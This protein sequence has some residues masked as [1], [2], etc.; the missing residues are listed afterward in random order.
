M[1]SADRLFEL[2]KHLKPEELS[3]L[4]TLLEEHLAS[5]EKSSDR[6][7]SYARTLA[8]FGTAH[9]DWSDVSSQKGKHLAEVYATR[10]G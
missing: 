3:R 10:R 8:L 1:E 5:V 9:S 2:A 6:T 7:R 4:V